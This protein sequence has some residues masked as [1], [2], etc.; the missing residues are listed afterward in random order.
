MLEFANCALDI[1]PDKS[2][3]GIVAL[4]INALV[5][6]PITYPVKVV[7]P[8]PPDDGFNVPA[9]VTGPLVA[10]LGVSPDKVVVNVVTPPVRENDCQPET[11]K[12]SNVPLLVL[13]RI[14]PVLPT[15]CAVVP[16]GNVTEPLPG[17]TALFAILKVGVDEPSPPAI[18]I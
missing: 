18:L 7:A 9:K 17:N 11:L 10:I 5:P 4:A 3:V 16:F 6:L 14:A 12:P 15:L 2:V 13:Y 8:V 1:V